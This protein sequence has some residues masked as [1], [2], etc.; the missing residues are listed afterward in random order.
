[1]LKQ[2]IFKRFIPDIFIDS[3]YDIDLKKLSN[4]GVNGFI[5]DIDNTLVT[6]DDLV[7][8]KH[9]SD[10]FETLKARGFKFCLVSNNNEKRVSEFAASLGSPYY[11]K[12]LK[13]RKKYL[14]AACEKIG[15]E[16]ERTAMVGDQLITDIY[17]GNRMGMLTVFVK[18]ISNREHWFVSL[19]RNIE[20]MML[21]GV[22]IDNKAYLLGDKKD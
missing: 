13:P 16:P 3:I 18:A 8:P 2:K 14:R 22:D 20:K 1:M 12:A 5:F 9:T 4:L 17:G 7:A 10:W 19:K 15:V 21:K 6:Y 11:Y